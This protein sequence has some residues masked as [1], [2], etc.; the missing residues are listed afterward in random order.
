MKRFLLLIILGLL[1]VGVASA[2]QPDSPDDAE[3]LRSA[4][5]SRGGG[6]P[7]IT[8]TVDVAVFAKP[9][10]TASEGRT[11]QLYVKDGAWSAEFME[12]KK[13]RG[14]RLIKKGT[15][16]WFMSPGLQKPVPISQRQR[17][18]GGAANGDIAST[19]YV[20]DY[21]AMRVTDETIDGVPCYVFDL[22]AREKSVTYDRI[23]YWVS[24]RELLGIRAD[25]LSSSGKLLKTARFDYD[26]RI[27][28][29]GKAT[30]FISQ[31]KIDDALQSNK[32]TTLSYSRIAVSEVPAAKFVF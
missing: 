32:L 20:R 18:T 8:W 23:R 17:L 25:F 6:L 13:I 26:N 24:K 4:D 14:Q 30:P 2:T 22:F 15:N 3:I 27:N 16:M 10:A 21:T 31:M 7:G 12:P 5:R 29:G 11:I 28:V 19:N 9:G 1:S